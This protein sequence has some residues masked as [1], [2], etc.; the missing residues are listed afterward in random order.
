MLSPIATLQA[1]GRPRLSRTA[2][3][4]GLGL[5]CVRALSPRTQGL[6]A[7][8]PQ[9]SGSV[10]WGGERSLPWST[11]SLNRPAS[12]ERRICRLNWLAC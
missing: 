9:V 11:Q 8:A 3:Q 6:A 2:A 12:W 5:I 7:P 1:G 10:G 4:L